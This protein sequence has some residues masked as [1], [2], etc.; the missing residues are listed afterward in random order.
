MTECPRWR[1]TEKHYINVP[2]LPDGTDVEWEHRETN[3]QNGR[4]VRKLHAV[5]M[6]L[7]PESPADCNYPGEVIVCRA[8]DGAHPLR[9]DY[10]FLGDPT[11]GME[12]LN[13]AAEAISA[14]LRERW[15]HPIESLP[16]AMSPNEQAFM[17]NMMKAFAGQAATLP[18]NA[19]VKDTEVADLKERLA[20]LEA[21]LAAQA[22]APEASVQRRA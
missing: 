21:L 5:P 14:S 15:E 8:V 4:A 16:T 11:P 22:K 17:E 10:I 18:G 9:N 20:K 7:D 1:L 2:T 19:V 12:P 3:T 13:D 6:F